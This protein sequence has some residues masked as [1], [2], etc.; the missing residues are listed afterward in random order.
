MIY[1]IFVSNSYH[2]ML[3][4]LL[5][6]GKIKRQLLKRNPNI[7]SISVI[8]IP[9]LFSIGLDLKTLFPRFLK[10]LLLN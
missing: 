7:Y 3:V 2:Y 1:F 10:R 8:E 9:R 4:D 5:F 6:N